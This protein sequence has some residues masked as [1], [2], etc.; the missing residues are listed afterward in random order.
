M[1][2]EPAAQSWPAELVRSANDVDRRKMSERNLLSA[3]ESLI[4]ITIIGPKYGNICQ[5]Y[6]SKKYSYLTHGVTIIDIYTF[7]P[8]TVCNL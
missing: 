7:S 4:S 3:E 6:T 5:N 2:F 1:D 8:Y